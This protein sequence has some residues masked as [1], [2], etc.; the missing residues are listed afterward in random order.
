MKFIKYLCAVAA[1]LTIAFL[2]CNA[3]AQSLWLTNIATTGAFVQPPQTGEAIQCTNVALAFL[4]P[5]AAITNLTTATTV[6]G[7]PSI[8]VGRNG[9]SFQ[10]R[11]GAAGA[12]TNPLRFTFNTS[13]DG[14]NFTTLNPIEFFTAPAGTLG[15]IDWTNFPASALNNVKYI[16]LTSISNTTAQIIG[17]T[18][19]TWSTYR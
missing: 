14:T 7:A 10:V 5:S 9:I 19:A 11:F 8:P 4:I 2:P 15:I 18:N 13:V 12:G 17:L 3:S 6:V 1:A 16:R